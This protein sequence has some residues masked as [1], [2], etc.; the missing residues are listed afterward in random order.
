MEAPQDERQVGYA[1]GQAAVNQKKT[2]TS[3]RKGQCRKKQ[4]GRIRIAGNAEFCSS[5]A[6]RK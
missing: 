5:A 1:A 6:K 2:E 4:W 3:H